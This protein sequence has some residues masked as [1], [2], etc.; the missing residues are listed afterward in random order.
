VLALAMGLVHTGTVQAF[1]FPWRFAGRLAGRNRSQTLRP[2]RSE[3]VPSPSAKDAAAALRPTRPAAPDP[4]GRPNKANSTGESGQ[5]VF[6]GVTSVGP[7]GRNRALRAQ[8]LSVAWPKQRWAVPTTQAPD[9]LWLSAKDRVPGT[10]AS[11]AYHAR[12]YKCT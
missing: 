6:V 1:G 2:W 3:S 5:H 9:W 10:M 8:F 12:V 11:A 4:T 7:R